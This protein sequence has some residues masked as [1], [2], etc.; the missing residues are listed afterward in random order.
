MAVILDPGAGGA[1]VATDTIGGEEHQFTK[2]E[3]GGAG[4]ATPVSSSVPLPVTGTTSAPLP[5][6]VLSGTVNVLGAVTASGTVAIT[7]TVN[8]QGTVS[9]S[10]T[11]PVSGSVTVNSITG[12]VNVEGSVSVKGTVTIVAI[13]AIPVSGT[14]SSITGTLAVGGSVTII[15]TLPRVE[16]NQTFPVTAG[17]TSQI[18]GSVGGT[19]DYLSHLSIVAGSTDANQVIL[20]DAA[21]GTFTVFGSVPGSG[22]GTYTVAVLAHSR[23]GPW[24][25]TTGGGVTVLAT[26]R[27]TN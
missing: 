14:L 24:R 1:T 23:F 5:V 7:G 19:G 8:V 25:V 22:K 4:V 20:A 17:T 3:F 12:T 6:T 2:M 26:G 16:R 9:V 15:G 10:G 11:T 27:F 13:T 21:Q 18:L